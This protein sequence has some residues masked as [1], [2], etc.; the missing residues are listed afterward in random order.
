MTRGQNYGILYIEKERRNKLDCQVF[1]KLDKLDMKIIDFEHK[2]N[3]IRFYLGADELESWYGDDWDDAPYEHNAG[4]VYDEFVTGHY[5]MVV[6]F[7][8]TVME[9]CD[10]QLNSRWC[11]LD[12]VT[13]AVPCI[14]IVP[15]K[16]EEKLWYN[17]NFDDYV[18]AAEVKRIY[19]GDKL[20]PNV[21]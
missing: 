17:N 11:K 4:R 20:E 1:D 19:F 8:Y 3:V 2:G 9:P 15:G 21:D 12:M 7:D 16:L 18:G 13:R 14:I 6:P 5:D 10:G